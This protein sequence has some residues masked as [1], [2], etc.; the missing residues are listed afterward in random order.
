MSYLSFTEQA[1][2]SQVTLIE[3][4]TMLDNNNA[5]SVVNAIV[6]AQERGC[7]FIIMD[8]ERLE[9]LSSAGVGAI[10][11]TIETCRDRGGD[12]ILCN[13]SG[14]IC[15]VL[16]VLDLL[17]FLTVKENRQQALAACG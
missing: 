7:K 13:V 5:E 12:I 3:L 15:H 2:S 11:G 1:L 8:C 17:E 14:T 4:G 16:R 6:Q 9:F 10:L